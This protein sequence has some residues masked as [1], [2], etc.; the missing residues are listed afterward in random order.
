MKILT[1]FGER[2]EADIPKWV[3]VI[4]VRE[5]FANVRDL[6]LQST[7]ISFVLKPILS[8]SDKTSPACGRHFSEGSSKRIVQMKSQFPCVEVYIQEDTSSSRRFVS[9]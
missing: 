5:A 3:A 7:N 6:W 8:V 1:R 9:M 2:Q 4:L